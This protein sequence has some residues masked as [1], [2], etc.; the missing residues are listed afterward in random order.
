ML[1]KP[2]ILERELPVSLKDI[3]RLAMLGLTA[4]QIRKVAEVGLLPDNSIHFHALVE[5][6]LQSTL[7]RKAN[8][9]LLSTTA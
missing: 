8:Q 5:A 9:C 6:T 3:E 1:I 7:Q 4:N 2:Q